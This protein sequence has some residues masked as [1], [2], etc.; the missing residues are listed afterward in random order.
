MKPIVH[1]IRIINLPRTRWKKS[2]LIYDS[3]SVI[4]L[5][6]K[7]MLHRRPNDVDNKDISNSELKMK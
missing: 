3:I 4:I 5:F 7:G 1:Y 2:M 6:L